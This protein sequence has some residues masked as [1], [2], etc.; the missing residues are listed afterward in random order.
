MTW[1]PT[2]HPLQWPIE[3]ANSEPLTAVTLRAFSVAEHR[4]ALADVSADED[5]QFEA[6]LLLATGL[7]ADVLEEI[8]R[9]DYV[10]LSKL[11][12]EYVTMPASYFLGANP[13]D[14]DDA[15]LL[16][17][18][19]AFGR[20]VDR[21]TIQVPAMKATKI[22]RKLKTGTQRADFISSHCTGLSP[23]DITRLSVPDWNQLQVRLDDFLNKPAAYFQSATS[24]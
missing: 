14:P 13:E 12:H 8:K 21:L 22:M 16:V 20:A 6:L 10:S 5:D 11:L 24:K 4:A 15:A 1:K 18:I 3:R 2:P 23:D 9:P 17:P 19:K 7:D